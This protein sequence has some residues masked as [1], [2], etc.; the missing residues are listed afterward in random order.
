MLVAVLGYIASLST[1]QVAGNKISIF[2]VNMFRFIF[3]ILFSIICI[4][5][6]GHSLKV[7]KKDMLKV[8]IAST[9]NL[10]YVSLLYLSTTQLPV[11]TLDGLYGGIYITI[12]TF[13]DAVQMKISKWSVI[14]AMI[15]GTGLI[16]LT[17]PWHQFKGNVIAPCDVL[18]NNLIYFNISSM[19]S[20]AS[21]NAPYINTNPLYQ[22][23]TPEALGYT[24]IIIGTLIT[25]VGD[26]IIRS[27][28]QTYSI[29]NFLFWG[30][31]IQSLITGIILLIMAYIQSG[32]FSFPTGTACLSFSIVLIITMTFT[33]MFLNITF[34]FLPVSKAAMVTPLATI[35]LYVLQRTALKTFHP[36]HANIMETVGILAIVVAGI[37]APVVSIFF[38][39]EK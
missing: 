33:H 30:G 37:L 10:V 20:N 4:S 38:E 19:F 18:D 39:S 29:Y 32:S 5:F 35:A 25:C 2:I 13:V 12:T 3:E 36:G 34:I 23:F 8:F 22:W 9:F 7:A 14:A 17:Q 24:Y 1:A 26:I 21:N 11:G 16:L 6:G 28:L 15:A 27:L 31:I